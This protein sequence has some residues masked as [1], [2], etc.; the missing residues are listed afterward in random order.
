M[1]I[2]N[3]PKEI[4]RKPS[5]CAQMLIGYIPVSKLESMGNKAGRRRGLANLFHSCMR[6]LFEPIV[7]HGKTGLPMMSGDGIW[8]RCHPI[9]ANFIGDYPEQ[10]LV[11]CTFS[12]RCPKC[13]A[14]CDQL[15]DYDTFSSRNYGKALETYAQADGDVRPFHSACRE[16]GIKPVAHPFWES[17]PHANIYVSITPDVLHQLLQ[18]VMKHVIAWV[19]NPLMFGPQG[20]DA[21]CHLMPPN[22][23]ITLFPRGIT[24]L[25]RVSGKE[26]KNMCRVLLGLIVDLPLAGGSSSARVLRAVRGLLD[27]LY[28]AQLPSQTHDTVSRLERSLVTFHENKD[29]FMDLGVRRHFN[30][31]K[32]HSLL[33]YSSSILLFGTTDNYNTEQT[34]RL[35]IDFTKDAYRATNHKDEYNQMTTWLERREK[36]QQHS[37]FIKWRQQQT[38]TSVL[39]QRPIAGPPLPGTR[40]LKMT[41]H[42]TIN[43]VSFEDIVYNYGAVDFQDLLGDFIAHLREP[44]ISGQALRNRGGNTLIPF[45]HVPVYH[46][47]KFR[48]IDDVIVD[49]VHIRPD[50]VDACGRT[51]QARFDTVLVR[52][53]Q[54]LDNM[55]RKQ[56]RFHL[57]MPRFS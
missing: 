16:S 56:G 30:I 5:R 40:Y 34:E 14:P 29:I 23:Q 21:R 52:T 42:P 51:M 1:T 54:Q 55:R 20:I 35:H 4:R 53:G 46:K 12:G 26:H 27:F 48:D 38:P 17:L 57:I 22:H 50:Q 33:H 6:A 10:V 13:E 49:S 36:L 9:L 32:F 3:I 28:L 31:P 8:R 37:M 25:S 39:P 11:T 24:S 15:G 18:G 47:I 19:S 7:S 2:G 44:H 45:R 41:Q 43:R